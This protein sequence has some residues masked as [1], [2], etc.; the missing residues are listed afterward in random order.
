[1]LQVPERGRGRIQVPPAPSSTR[2]AEF[3][4]GELAVLASEG[5]DDLDQDLESSSWAGRRTGER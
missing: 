2:D 3:F 4:S 1:M 5:I